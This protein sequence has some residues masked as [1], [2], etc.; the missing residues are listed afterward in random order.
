MSWRSTY[1]SYIN[2]VMSVACSSSAIDKCKQTP[3]YRRHANLFSVI[4][5]Q[6]ITSSGP[7]PLWTRCSRSVRGRTTT[8]H[9]QA[10]YHSHMKHILS[11]GTNSTTSPPTLIRVPIPSWRRQAACR[12]LHHCAK[13]WM[14]GWVLAPSVSAKPL[15]MLSR[16]RQ[17]KCTGSNMILVC[18]SRHATPRTHDYFGTT[19]VSTLVRQARLRVGRKGLSCAGRSRCESIVQCV[20]TPSLVSTCRFVS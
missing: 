13:S 20:Y 10:S 15:S 5:Q 12:S 4:L 18:L 7:G 6:C 2:D 1:L 11:V 9:M 8:I 19:F 16:H 17:R 3:T 14:H